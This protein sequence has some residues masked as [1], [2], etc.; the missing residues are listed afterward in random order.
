MAHNTYRAVTS[1]APGSVNSPV[2]HALPASIVAATLVLSACSGN[3]PSHD[4]LTSPSARLIQGAA[5]G[6]A[7]TLLTEMPPLDEPQASDA[8]VSFVHMMLTHHAQALEMTAL[9]PSRTASD[10]V[11]LF[12]E[13]IELS[14]AGEIDLMV[15]WLQTRDLAVPAEFSEAIEEGHADHGTAHQDADEGTVHEDHE[16]PGLLTAEEME[17]LAMSDGEEFDRLFLQYMHY[18]HDGALTMVQELW[19]AGGGQELELGQLVNH[20]DSDQ[21]I[22]MD[23]IESMLAERGTTL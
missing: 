8:D 3:E 15:R 14:Q 16:M 1:L 6:E 19:D 7:G 9:V 20:I 10:D 21:R 2:R 23:R 22:E 18:H 17:G 5:P 13:R 11:P 4:D 12:A